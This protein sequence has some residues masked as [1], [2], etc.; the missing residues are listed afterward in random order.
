[1]KLT[2]KIV[3]DV[4]KYNKETGVLTW[5]ERPKKYFVRPEDAR[6]W[7]KLHAGAPAFTYFRQNRYVG[8][9]FAHLYLRH[10]IIWLMVKGEWPKFVAFRDLNPRNTAWSNLR[11][12]D[13]AAEVREFHN[14]VR[15][16]FSPNTFPAKSGRHV[17]RLGNVYLGTFDTKAE[18]AQAHQ[19]AARERW[20]PET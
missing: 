11:E 2:Q 18:A 9:L 10:H 12:C 14:V 17:A 16:Q 5:R 6:S 7:N 1:M 13:S 8:M 20:A 4:L 19:V 3:R 15:G